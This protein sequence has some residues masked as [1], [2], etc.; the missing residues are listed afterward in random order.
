MKQKLFRFV[1]I[2][3][4]GLA[5]IT[6]LGV[7][8]LATVVILALFTVSDAEFKS[9]RA[10]SEGNS[11]RQLADM[12]VNI[13]T[14]QV[15]AGAEGRGV[16]STGAATRSIWA[17]QPG[18]IRVY[19]QA[20]QFVMG[21]RLYSSQEMV[22]SNPS[23]RQFLVSD[24]PPTAW[25]SLPDEWVDMNAPVVKPSGSVFFPIIDPFAANPGTD[26][27]IEGFSYQTKLHN[28]QPLN[29]VVQAANNTSRL[30]MPVRWLYVLRDG[31][32]GTMTN[33]APGS[34]TWNAGPNGTATPTV[35]NPIIGRVAFWTD[36]ECCKINI[37]TAGEPGIWMTPT[38]IHEKDLAYASAPPAI[39]EYQ[40]YPGHPATVA[41]SSVLYPNPLHL[42]TRYDGHSDWPAGNPAGWPDAY[43]NLKNGMYDLAPK[44]ARGGSGDGK[45]P[46]SL[47]DTDLGSVKATESVEDI[48]RGIVDSKKEHLFTSPDE[49]YYASRVSGGVRS[50]N[51]LP[52][53]GAGAPLIVAS[54]LAYQRSFLTATSRASELN[55]FG[56]PRVAMWPVPDADLGQNY[57]TPYDTA[58]AMASTLGKVE[59]PLSPAIIP[60]TYYF[61]RRDADSSNVDM[62]KGS[63]GAL[64]R[65]GDLMNYL[66]I[67]MSKQM[68][69]GKSLATKY[70]DDQ[71]QLLVEI[72]DY[73]R[74]TNLYDS[75]LD[76]RYVTDVLKGKREI[77][78]DRNPVGPGAKNINTQVSSYSGD[79]RLWN[80][81]PRNANTAI[82]SYF[83]YTA[84]RFDTYRRAGDVSNTPHSSF[85]GNFNGGNPDELVTTGAY[86]G[87]GQVK[88]ILWNPRGSGK[89]YKGFGRFPTI[90]E[91][92]LHFICTA[93]GKPDAGSWDIDGTK[94][95]GKTARIVHPTAIFETEG[96]KPYRLHSTS[97]GRNPD[98]Y[99]YSNYPPFPSKATLDLWKVQ[100]VGTGPGSI[101]R[102]PGADSSNWNAT[103]DTDTPL[104]PDEKRVQVALLFELFV[105][106]AGYTKYTP[107]FALA[108][109][110]N[111]IKG[112]EIYQTGSTA[113][114]IPP[115]YKEMFST[116]QEMVVK[117]T[118]SQWGSRF[119]ETVHGTHNVSP[120]GGGYSPGA[121]VNGRQVKAIG[122]MP[123][124]PGYFDQTSTSPHRD[125]QNYQFVSSFFTVHR[126]NPIKFKVSKPIAVTIFGSHDYLGSEKPKNAEVVQIV[127][128]KFP[129]GEQDTPPPSL[130][131]YARE[132]HH[133]ASGGAFTETTAQQA[134]RW[135]TFNAMGC[136]NRWSGRL[137]I[138]GGTVNSGNVRENPG[139]NNN[140]LNDAGLYGR[141]RNSGTALEENIPYHNLLYGY[142]PINGYRGVRESDN[143]SYDISITG[144]G[145][146]RHYG[147]DA[148]RSIV[149]KHGDYR[150]LAAQVEVPAETWVPHRLWTNGSKE[151]FAHSI[152]GAKSDGEVGTDLGGQTGTQVSAANRLLSDVWYPLSAVPDTPLTLAASKISTS[153][154]DFDQGVGLMRDGPYINK[155]D[156]GNLSIGS[157]WNAT[158]GQWYRTRNAYF[159]DSFLQMPS[160]SA[161]FTP[162]RMI[163]SPGVLGSLPTSV[164]ALNGEWRTLLFRPAVS[165]GSF[166]HEG[167]NVRNGNDVADHNVLDLFWMPTIEP[168]AISDGFSTAGKININYQ[169]LP[170]TH[171]IRATA[172]H[173][174]LKGEIVTAF[175]KDQ[176]KSGLAIVKAK[177]GATLA[178]KQWKTSSKSGV[179]PYESWT[180]NEGAVWHRGVDIPRT[181]GQFDQKFAQEETTQADGG[182]FR[183][184]S[185][186]C[187]MHIVP[188]MARDYN[189]AGAAD[190]GLGSLPT[191]T[192]KPI[193][194][195]TMDTAMAAFW[196]QNATTGDNTRERVYANIYQKITTKSNTYRVHFIAQSVKKARSVL[197]TD[198]DSTKDSATSE[199]RG[200]AL[201]ERYLDFNKSQGELGAKK[202]LDYATGTDPFTQPSLESM[203][204]YRIIE[205]K[206]FAP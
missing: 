154:R 35:D 117:S 104:G 9:S 92:S 98:A 32:V 169:M 164:S 21:R 69:G 119:G 196:E 48:F 64:K 203:Y 204:R 37:N 41:L 73:I 127:N 170:F 108:L 145:E 36:D 147:S 198:W 175:G 183:T 146:Y 167:R 60:Q 99:Y 172:M 97:T 137:T 136:L 162:N 56:Y 126:T 88:P 181:L 135:W 52:K 143:D 110:G 10:Y 61:S 47:D 157:F 57:R 185:E 58:I 156:D 15:Q 11:A 179:N 115:G 166:K 103:L 26:P 43:T 93:D 8:T 29:G 191:D 205:F 72:F 150:L 77:W 90:S 50:W 38:V 107:D 173:A 76:E 130:V 54:K 129:Q 53:D 40:R 23:E 132:K 131:V 120:M 109:K 13:V 30:P 96:R 188:R 3:R 34:Y 101:G 125:M 63:A 39:F 70:G 19:N 85:H 105:P 28:A 45:N 187:E 141:F 182:L 78:D 195:A 81:N 1:R 193:S 102:F 62:G 7:V 83:T 134:P 161:F 55:M 44:L 121:L 100:A 140:P 112:I 27:A 114:S 84:P 5:L 68:P 163:P 171:I 138:T 66:N 197:P 186:I 200:S 16:A 75:F 106:N 46:F 33:S 194:K 201:F 151:L 148:V 192:S 67:M 123:K 178:H 158:S 4:Q 51:N 2:N 24:L 86:P 49:L 153:R 59:N 199:Y 139:P 118:P 122:R 94:S 116:T 18:A 42:T 113:K 159:L 95:G 144:M 17:S 176:G 174:V 202:F 142:A 79:A 160:K 190:A 31:N 12:A 184:A 111:D 128:L 124:D 6:V 133:S 25:D 87:H 152:M 165:V 20:G 89:S 177:E 180:N 168:W 91:V 22:F 155:P 74:C 189:P 80:E 82:P 71:K 65:N 206:Q 14:G 149:P